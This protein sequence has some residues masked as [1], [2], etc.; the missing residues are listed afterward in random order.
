MTKRCLLLEDTKR[1]SGSIEDTV[2]NE[3]LLKD[4][5]RPVVQQRVEI[6]KDYK[7]SLAGGSEL[8]RNR[9]ISLC[10]KNVSKNIMPMVE[11]LLTTTRVGD[12][13]EW[14]MVGG[15]NFE[16]SV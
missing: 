12:D 10:G 13:G 4:T 7:R 9:N 6:V 8:R 11:W 14:N 16:G 5:R 15:C 2:V 1:K 3:T